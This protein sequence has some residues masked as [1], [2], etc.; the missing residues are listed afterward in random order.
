MPSASILILRR[1]ALIIARCRSTLLPPSLNLPSLPTL[2][3]RIIAVQ[4]VGTSLPTSVRRKSPPPPASSPISTEN[5][6]H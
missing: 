5:T 1:L 4:G 3:P 2:I 6:R